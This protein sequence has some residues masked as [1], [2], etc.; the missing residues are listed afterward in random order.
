MCW[1]CLKII[2]KEVKVKE[3]SD[4]TRLIIMILCVCI[5][6]GTAVIFLSKIFK[7]KKGVK[8]IPSI[9]ALLLSVFFFAKGLF[10]FFKARL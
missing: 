10:F 9:I 6:F 3:A 8:Y 4:M 5:C 2:R 1:M 7:S